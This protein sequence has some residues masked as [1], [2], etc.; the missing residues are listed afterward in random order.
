MKKIGLFLIAALLL[1]SITG[2]G[3]RDENPPT[4]PTTGTTPATAPATTPATV[5]PTTQ[6]SPD[7]D[8]TM[9]TNIPDP[10]TNGDIPDM[11]DGMEPTDSD[12][13]VAEIGPDGQ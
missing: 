7:M 3:R 10:N 4:T 9:D 2:C 13:S 11:E 5:P 6:G 8:P 12:S 1:L